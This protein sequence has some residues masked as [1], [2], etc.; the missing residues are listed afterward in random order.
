[1]QVIP[2]MAIT[3][4]WPTKC[5]MK[6]EAIRLKVR[7]PL[8]M[9][10]FTLSSVLNFPLNIRNSHLQSWT[11]ISQFYSDVWS[12]S[13]IA[14]ERKQT[15]SQSTAANTPASGSHSQIVWWRY[16]I[17]HL[18]VLLVSVARSQRF[19]G[20]VSK[21]DSNILSVLPGVAQYQDACWWPLS[22]WCC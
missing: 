18:L 1:M 21:F 13:T 6:L 12:R 11:T 22:F 17:Q 3:C 19:L 14:Q 16:P 4:H 15:T 7:H 9:S 2:W 5:F 20:A 10:S 8:S